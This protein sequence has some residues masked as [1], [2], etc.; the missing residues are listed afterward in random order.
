MSSAPPDIT[1]RKVKFELPDEL[2]DVLPGVD[3][4]RET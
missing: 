2:D 3:L 1:V 4:V